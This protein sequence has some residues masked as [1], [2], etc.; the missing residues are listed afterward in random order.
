MHSAP[1]RA[2]ALRCLGD[3]VA[4]SRPNQ[5]VLFASAVQ[6]ANRGG[7]DTGAQNTTNSSVVTEPALLAALRVALRGEDAGER[8]AA[9]TL[10]AR[11]L[12]G[13]P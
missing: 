8:V 1:V 12:F 3:L 7:D 9:E 4:E 13:N 11:C 2:F 10:F 5:D 6:I